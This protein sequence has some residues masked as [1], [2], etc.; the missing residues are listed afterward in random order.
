LLDVLALVFS[1]LEAS[2]AL[3]SFLGLAYLSFTCFFKD[4]SIFLSVFDFPAVDGLPAFFLFPLVAFLSSFSAFFSAFSS[5][6]F[7][8]LAAFLADLPSSF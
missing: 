2:F 6:F 8:F 5:D 1:D 4:F 3:A 7:S